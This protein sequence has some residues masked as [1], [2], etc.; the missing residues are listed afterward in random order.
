MVCSCTAVVIE[1]IVNYYVVEIARQ[2]TDE[3]ES[4]AKNMGDLSAARASDFS[5]FRLPFS[6][7][8]ICRQTPH[9]QKRAN[10]SFLCGIGWFP[11]QKAPL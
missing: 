9:S 11:P 8:V 5:L 10:L 2:G 4:Y 3:S 7:T 1:L 6:R